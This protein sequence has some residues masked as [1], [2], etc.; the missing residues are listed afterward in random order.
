MI[1]SA[2]APVRILV[3]DD[4][5]ASR[6]VLETVLRR[7]GF[8]VT[9]AGN[10]VEALSRL[11]AQP[12]DLVLTDVKMP[13]MNGLTLLRQIHARAPDTVVVLIA[14]YGA[15]N[16]AIRAIR[17]GAY[18][19]LAKPFQLDE[20]YVLVDNAVERIRLTKE[21]RRLLRE[22]EG[23]DQ[24]AKTGGHEGAAAEDDGVSLERVQALE[25]HLLRIY[26]RQPGVPEKDDDR[27]S[28]RRDDGGGDH[29][30]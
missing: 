6:D 28:G 26:P 4:D 14:G 18:D 9:T 17:E 13:G 12:V 30:G 19:Y 10:G 24:R 15:I 16:W 29:D 20:L 5:E 3:V 2:E 22:M 23:V 25:R 7:K 8:N 27:V 21:N 11:D 1:D